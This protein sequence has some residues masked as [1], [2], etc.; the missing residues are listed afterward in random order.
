MFAR[1][2][3][4]KVFTRLQFVFGNRLP[5]KFIKG[6]QRLYRTDCM[7]FTHTRLY[8]LLMASDR[9]TVQRVCLVSPPTRVIT[10]C[11]QVQEVY[12]LCG[13]Q[14]KAVQSF[15]SQDNLNSAARVRRLP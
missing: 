13:V 2:K 15:Q 11:S 1:E 7:F 8:L 6:V 12:A 3:T 9:K 14:I 10:I 4:G 5:L